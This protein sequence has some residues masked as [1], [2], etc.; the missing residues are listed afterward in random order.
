MPID[1]VVALLTVTLL[2]VVAAR[3]QLVLVVDVEVLALAIALLA[4]AFHPVDTHGLFVFGFVRAEIVTLI[5]SDQLI[6]AQQIILLM[7][8]HENSL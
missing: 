3:G 4:L 2:E 8:L 5:D 1:T 7:L 6:V